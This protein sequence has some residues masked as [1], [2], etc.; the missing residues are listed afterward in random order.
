MLDGIH[1]VLLDVDDTLVDTQGAFRSALMVAAQPHLPGAPDPADLA[2][3]WRTDRHGHYRAYTSG[4]MDYREQRMRRANDLHAHFG[5]APLDD[6]AY[7]AWNVGFEEAFQGAWAVFDDAAPL[8]DALEAR[9]VPYGAVSNA[10][11]AYQ[12]MKLDRVGLARMPMLVGVDTF[13]V[14]KP[15]ARVFIEGARLLGTDPAATAYVGD[16]PDID[17]LAASAAGLRGIWLD[18]PGAQRPAHSAGAPERRIEG[19]LELLK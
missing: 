11:V 5:G 19:L 8:L 3:F 14:G 9:G 12:R 18:R 17:A 2:L 13:G 7:D 6:Q 10:G 16:E 1:G 15:D 4:L